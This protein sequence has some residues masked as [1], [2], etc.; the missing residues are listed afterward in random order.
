MGAFAETCIDMKK[1]KVVLTG[2]WQFGSFLFWPRW[3]KPMSDSRG[4]K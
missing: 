2:M 4:L 3:K 1:V